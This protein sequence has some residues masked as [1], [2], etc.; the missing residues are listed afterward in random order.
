MKWQTYQF[1]LEI[2]SSSR[3]QSAIFDSINQNETKRTHERTERMI[4]IK[5]G[6][7]TNITKELSQKKKRGMAELRQKNV[8]EV[9]T[10]N[11]YVCVCVMCIGLY[12][13]FDWMKSNDQ[14][15]VTLIAFIINDHTFSLPHPLS[16]QFDAGYHLPK[17]K[18]KNHPFRKFTSKL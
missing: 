5:K 3:K 6:R 14:I 15:D 10:C 12:C 13:T 8:S 2:E 18:Q 1:P 9:C 17:S 7:K 11:R 4:K 16:H